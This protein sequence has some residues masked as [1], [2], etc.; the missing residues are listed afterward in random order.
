[1]KHLRAKFRPYND[2]DDPDDFDPD[3]VYDVP[4]ANH[5]ADIPIT[6]EQLARLQELHWDD[7]TA[8]D[9]EGLL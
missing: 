1:L 9:W 6:A 2:E 7:R 5:L 8:K 4:L 3:Y